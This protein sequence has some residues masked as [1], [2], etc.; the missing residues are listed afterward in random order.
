MLV[1]TEGRRRKGLHGW[2]AS[3]IH[4]HEF[5]QTLEMVKSRETWP[6]AIC[7]VTKESDTP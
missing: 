6:V 4:E 3:L 5:E 1:K 2:M 7:E